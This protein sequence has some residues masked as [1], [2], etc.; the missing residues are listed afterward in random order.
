MALMEKNKEAVN[1]DDQYSQG[2]DAGAVK[3]MD[4]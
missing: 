1:I 4:N 3:Y 2:L